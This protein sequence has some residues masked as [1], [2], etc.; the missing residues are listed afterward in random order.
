MDRSIYYKAIYFYYNI[1]IYTG[2]IRT[3]TKYVYTDIQV[4]ILFPSFTK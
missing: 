3:S 2:N 4:Y 1:K